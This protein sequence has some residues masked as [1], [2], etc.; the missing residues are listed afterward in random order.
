MVNDSNSYT[1]QAINGKRNGHG[2]Q[3]W[4]NGKKYEGSWKDNAFN[5]FGIY[6]MPDG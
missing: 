1:G 6:T 5:G 4:Q 3:T 2:V